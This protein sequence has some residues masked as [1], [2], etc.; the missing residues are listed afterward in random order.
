M[1]FFFNGGEK[2]E[3]PGEKHILIPSPK[4]VKTY[5]Q[6][7]EMSAFAVTETLLSEIENEN[8]D[9]YLVNFANCDMV[10]HT[11]NFKSAVKAVEAVDTRIA[12]WSR[13]ATKGQSL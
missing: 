2:A 7:P 5:D 13:L 8:Y 3:F 11:G 4:E 12:D 6:K 9:F 1:T 10:G